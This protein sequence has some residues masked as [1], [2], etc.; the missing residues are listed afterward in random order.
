MA[1]AVEPLPNRGGMTHDARRQIT[2]VAGLEHLSAHG[3]T[4]RTKA[5][6]PCYFLYSVK[7]CAPLSTG[8][9]RRK[10]CHGVNTRHFGRHGMPSGVFAREQEGLHS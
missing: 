6:F 1:F 2:A 3:R 5:K 7:P 9:R 4:S 8:K 10:I